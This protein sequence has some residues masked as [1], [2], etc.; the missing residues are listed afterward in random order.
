MVTRYP[1]LYLL[2]TNLI[3]YHHGSISQTN[4]PITTLI[5]FMCYKIVQYNMTFSFQ[6][7]IHKQI[8]FHEHLSAH[9]PISIHLLVHIVDT[10]ICKPCTISDGWIS[11]I[12]DGCYFLPNFPQIFSFPHKHWGVTFMF[13]STND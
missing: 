5:K 3:T 1:S 7:Q 6:K 10:F 13:K 2:S 12:Q 11:P 8:H 9:A 4:S